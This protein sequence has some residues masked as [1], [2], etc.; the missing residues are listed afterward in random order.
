MPKLTN[1]ERAK[2]FRKRQKEKA[3]STG[4]QKN[5]ARTSTERSREHRAREREKRPSI[6]STTRPK[7][8]QNTPV[9]LEVNCSVEVILCKHLLCEISFF[10]NS[11][12]IRRVVQRSN[13]WTCFKQ[14]NTL[15][16]FLHDIF[17]SIFILFKAVFILDSYLLNRFK[18]HGEP[19]NIIESLK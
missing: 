2:N 14:S 15:H 19:K 10:R 4:Q 7:Q 3:K 11:Q 16:I 12:K 1:A 5:P 9:S 6:I 13:W 18:K 8:Q 17:V